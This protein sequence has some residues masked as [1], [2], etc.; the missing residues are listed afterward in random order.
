MSLPM[1]NVKIFFNDVEYFKCTSISCQHSI[2]GFIALKTTTIQGIATQLRFKDFLDILANKNTMIARVEI[3]DKVWQK[4][5]ISL[6]DIN[7]SIDDNGFRITIVLNDLLSTLKTSDIV[8]V[9][10]L[11]NKTL[12]GTLQSIFKELN[13]KDYKIING[14]DIKIIDL[15]NGGDVETNGYISCE[16]FLGNICSLYQL[17][18]I[19]NGV[20]A[21]S[22]EKYNANQEII[23]N[24]IVKCNDGKVITS[25]VSFVEKTGNQNVNNASKIVILNTE[26]T[27]TDKNTSVIV[28]FV[29]GTPNT[30]QIRT[31]AMKASYKQISQAIT[32]QMMGMNM[33]AN[34]YVYKLSV[35]I[36]D[37]NKQFFRV[38]HLIN[39]LDEQLGI[40]DK[41]NIIGI[42]LTIDSQSGTNTIFNLTNQES[43]STIGN[44][45]NK[46]SLMKK[47]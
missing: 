16:Q 13:I 20:D 47:R 38:N 22:I 28:N 19:S 21:I 44:L 9:L 3:Y 31:I 29:N 7:Y 2:D 8:E 43:V 10:Y 23:D 11:K 40:D 46:K 1:N 45:K 24:F 37:K 18:L 36:F 35:K 4:G 34:S 17:I 6:T 12:Q 25:N 32:Y 39:V 14:T 5:F 30:Q 15:A 41:M 27:N 33:V 42:A 26:P